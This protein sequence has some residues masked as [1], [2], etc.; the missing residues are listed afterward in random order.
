MTTRLAL[1]AV[2][3]P[4]LESLTAAE[5]RRLGIEPTGVEPGGVS[6]Q[7][8]LA[9]VARANL[10]LRT[11]S[12]I[13]VRLG[14]FH[15][16]A[17]GELERKAGLLPWREWLVADQPLTVRAT[18]RKSRLFHQG[19]VAE[20]VIAAAGGRPPEDAALS[21]DEEA[22][23]AAQLVVVRLFRD[24]AT[25]SLDSSGSLLH[26][27]GYRL[28][29][30][31]APLRETL[32]AALLLGSGWHPVEPL[33][34]PFCGSGTIPIEAALLARRLPPGLHRSF[35]FQRWA[36]W[37]ETEWRSLIDAARDQSLSRA[38]SAIIAADRDAGAIAAGRGNAARAGV[39]QDIEF[40]CEALS[41]L[42]PPTG[43]GHLITNPP[44]GVRVGDPRALRDLYARL[45]QVARERLAGWRLTLLLP[46]VPLERATG[47]AF[48]ESLRTSN[49]GLTVRVVHARAQ[50]RGVVDGPAGAL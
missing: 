25:I 50:A 48:T 46:T 3:A 19:A 34:D 37:N 10:W 16:R 8:N 5:L 36:A 6:F 35:A 43:T 13:L 38:P 27:R 31:K 39:E 15:V 7:G 17:L 14:T 32:A 23:P 12:R 18:C 30:A 24:E 20:R 22:E 11:A 33:V 9:D 40:R 44:Y 45:G 28:E 42:D 1:Y 21:T 47:L 26:R 2:T 41:L 29:T 49:G 4:G